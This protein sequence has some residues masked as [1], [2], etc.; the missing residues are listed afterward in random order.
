V[1][2]K[3]PGRFA[4]AHSH[5]IHTMLR[6]ASIVVLLSLAGAAAHAQVQRYFP[7]NALRGELLVLT[8]PAVLIDGKEARL[9]PGARIRGE[10]NMLAMSG[11]LADRK[12]TV[13]YTLELNGMLLDVWVLT[14]Q[15]MARKPWPKSLEEARSW[16]FDPA[17]QVWIKP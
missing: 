7:A 1:V 12:L 17:G 6:C 8:P 15:E 2:F 16:T 10:N 3:A 5:W 11:A 13:H 9:A 14:P 4:F